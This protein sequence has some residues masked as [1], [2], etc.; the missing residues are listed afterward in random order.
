MVGMEGLNHSRQTDIRIK[1]MISVC[2]DKNPNQYEFLNQFL[3]F[4]KNFVSSI[5]Q[6][7]GQ[8]KPAAIPFHLILKAHSSAVI[9]LVIR[10]IKTRSLRQL[11]PYSH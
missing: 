9:L 7:L 3:A 5:L 10:V 8:S 6:N 4:L 1:D 11:V 2:Y